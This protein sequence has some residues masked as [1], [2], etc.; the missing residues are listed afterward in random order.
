M[1]HDIGFQSL[2]DYIDGRCQPAEKAKVEAHLAGCG[3]CRKTVVLMQN[4]NVAVK[5]LAGTAASP[6]FDREFERRLSE[7]VRSREDSVFSRVFG[8]AM[9]SIKEAL[10]S[11]HPILARTAVG[12]FL[13]ISAYGVLKFGP[14]ES[15]SIAL[16]RGEVSVYSAKSMKWLAAAKDMKLA[17][18][19]MVDVGPGSVADIGHPGKYTVR[20]KG[21]SE[22]VVAKLLPKYVG[23]TAGYRIVKGKA[24]IAIEKGFRGSKFVMN[25]PE[26]VAV[27]LGT[28]FM[29][30][31][32]AQPIG[33]TK[34]GVLEGRVKVRSI[35]VPKG[36]T[37]LEQVIVSGGEVTEIYHGSVPKTPRQLLDEEWQEMVEFYR[38]GARSQVALLVSNGKYRTRE[39]LRP[40]PI[41]IFDVKPGTVGRSLEETIRIIDEAIKTKDESRHLEGIKRIEDVLTRYPNPDYEPQLLLFIG[42]YY[43]YLGMYSQAIAAFGKVYERYPKSTFASMALCASGMIYEEKLK[44]AAK[45]KYY[46]GLV[47]SKYPGS[48]ERA[49]LIELGKK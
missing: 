41:Y 40:C 21:P 23:G 46:Y 45:A 15:P 37:G 47:V 27:A 25:T 38:I 16:I 30:D 19:D 14:A 12:L 28:E 9:D 5:N 49:L 44:E 22:M 17:K 36:R 11:P 32:P 48:P 3:S 20:L 43:N 4:L 26:A 34:L 7:A 1:R 18:G 35:Y 10:T 24:Y 29:V 2:S 42:A 33:M 8:E 31:V 13:I 39:L 6:A